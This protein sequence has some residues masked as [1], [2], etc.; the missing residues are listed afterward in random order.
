MSQG[1]FPG[2]DIS[3]IKGREFLVPKG[4]ESEESNDGAL[5]PGMPVKT[6]LS[7]E[8]TGQPWKAVSS[9]GIG[10]APGQGRPGRR[11][12]MVHGENEAWTGPQDTEVMGRD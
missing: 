2:T 9:R 3:K 5:G 7:P 1:T 6:E 12:T 4:L 8:G 11:R 10:S